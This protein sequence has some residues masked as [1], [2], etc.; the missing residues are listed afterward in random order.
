[1]HTQT[2]TRCSW[3]RV[4]ILRAAGAG[5]LLAASPAF[6]ATDQEPPQPPLPS[7]AFAEVSSTGVNEQGF[8]PH[9]LVGFGWAALQVGIGVASID[10]PSLKNPDGT[11]PLAFVPHLGLRLRLAG[12]RRKGAELSLSVN[13]GFGT[14]TVLAV[15]GTDT[16][17]SE[18]AGGYFAIGPV[19]RY[20]ITPSVAFGMG[21]RLRYL[22]FVDSDPSSEGL[23]QMVTAF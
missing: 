11:V 9:F 17:K 21:M 18:K 16:L 2:N 4:N 13:A 10:L 15:D 5:L 1:M 22:S 3:G 14:T 23:L 6:A 19:A 12:D 7:V 8:R 20:W